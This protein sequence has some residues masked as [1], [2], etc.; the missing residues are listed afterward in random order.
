MI[1]E[2][3][4]TAGFTLVAHG[5]NPAAALSLFRDAESNSARRG[6]RFSRWW[7]MMGAAHA[8][9][10]PGPLRDVHR[11][12]VYA[13]HASAINLGHLTPLQQAFQLAIRANLQLELRRADD[14]TCAFRCHGGALLG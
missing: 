1:V 2:L 10:L 9:M 7:A 12:H 5:P 14:G 6:D 8:H 13:K 4:I 11:V 3:Q